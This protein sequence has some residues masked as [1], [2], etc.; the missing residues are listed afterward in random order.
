MAAEITQWL[1][2]FDLQMQRSKTANLL[3]IK[4]VK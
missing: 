2:Y 3:N 1:V 4:Y